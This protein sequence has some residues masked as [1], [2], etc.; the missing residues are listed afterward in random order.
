MVLIVVSLGPCCSFSCLG[1]QATTSTTA[2]TQHVFEVGKIASPF[3]AHR[4]QQITMGDA[5]LPPKTVN[6][7]ALDI[8]TRPRRLFAPALVR[9]TT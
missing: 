1:F 4:C 3:S 7:K 5:G 9:P 6:Y 8:T 2:V